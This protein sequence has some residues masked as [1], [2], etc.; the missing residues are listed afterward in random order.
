[1]TNTSNKTISVVKNVGKVD[2][3]KG[4]VTILNFAVSAYSGSG[5]KLYVKPRSSDVDFALSD[6]FEIK[7]EDVAITV[8]G[9]RKE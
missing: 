8:I 2:Y 3:E 7:T 6:Y 5:I 4:I 1:V 9:T